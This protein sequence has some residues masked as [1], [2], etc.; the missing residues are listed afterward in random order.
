MKFLNLIRKLGK[1]IERNPK[2]YA[3]GFG[4]IVALILLSRWMDFPLKW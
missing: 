4:V 2:A 3:I 1:R